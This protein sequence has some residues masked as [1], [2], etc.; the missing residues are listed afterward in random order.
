MLS[1]PGFSG[2]FCQ[3]T[4]CPVLCSGNGVFTNGRCFCHVNY[5]GPTCDES[6]SSCPNGRCESIETRV[7]EAL[8]ANKE[9]TEPTPNQQTLQKDPE[10]TI[11]SVSQDGQCSKEC[12][13]HGKC[14]NGICVCHNGWNGENCLVRGCPVNNCNSNGE[15]QLIGGENPR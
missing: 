13:K 6:I 8:N 2:K 4:L 1:Y 14:V 12:D 5:K 15:C 3:E 7:P 11:I 10:P 9:I